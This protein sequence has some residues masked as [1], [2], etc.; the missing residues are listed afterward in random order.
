M[1]EWGEWV[2]GLVLGSTAA[3]LNQ[4]NQVRHLPYKNR[5][6]S[7]SGACVGFA[8]GPIGQPPLRVW[9]SASRCM[10]RPRPWE[11]PRLQMERL[12]APTPDFA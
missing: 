3:S 9:A 8:R 7:T 2:S 5:S 10:L 12:S 6:N 4:E 11:P 1:W